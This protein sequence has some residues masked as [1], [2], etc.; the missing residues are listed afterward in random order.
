VVVKVPR[1][2]FEKFPQADPALNTQ[3]KSVGEAMA[4]GRTFKEA[5]QKC[6]RSLE[7]GRSGLG[8]D[9][10]PWRVGSEVFG[11]R[12]I[13]PRELITRKL[14]E[15]ALDCL[16]RH[17]GAE[18]DVE[19]AWVPG[20]FELPLIAQKLARDY[21]VDLYLKSRLDMLQRELDQLLHGE[22]KADQLELT[23][24]LKPALTEEISR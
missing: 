20:S 17:G 3:M 9:G 4:I 10:K 2:A 16:Q 11:D 7:I 22:R 15:G 8:G 12:D 18:E 24:F 1:F 21:E 14:L 6:L 19:I 23:D 13:L 5:L